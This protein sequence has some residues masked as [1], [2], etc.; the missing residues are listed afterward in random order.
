ML[1]YGAHGSLQRQAAPGQARACVLLDVSSAAALTKLLQ[2]VDGAN[3]TR[4]PF[5]VAG[6]GLPPPWKRIRR[7]S[8]LVR[9]QALQVLQLAIEHAYVRAEELVRGAGEKIA[10][11]GLHVHRAMRDI[12]HRVYE[13]QRPC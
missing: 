1:L 3:N 7:R 10:I 8:D 4:H 11:E 2:V 5:V 9:G 6:T 13:D 12:L